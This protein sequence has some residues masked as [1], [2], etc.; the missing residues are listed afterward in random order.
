MRQAG[1]YELVTGAR[2]YE[3]VT[4]ARRYEP[5]TGARRYEPVTGARRYEPVTG[6]RRYEPVTGAR[7]C[8]LVTGARRYEPVTGA[9]TVSNCGCSKHAYCTCAFRVVPV[10]PKQGAGN[11]KSALLVALVGGPG[12]Q[13]WRPGHVHACVLVL[14]K[15]RDCNVS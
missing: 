15:V 4:G 2:R 3:L 8:E 1:R 10:L 13:V 9:C 14:H 12:M 6:A 7:R 5:V 11:A